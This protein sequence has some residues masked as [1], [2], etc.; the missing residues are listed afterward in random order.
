MSKRVELSS[1]DYKRT[2][3]VRREAQQMA[4]AAQGNDLK[5]AEQS[6][7]ILLAQVNT[8]M[9]STTFRKKDFAS[10]LQSKGIA[11]SPGSETLRKTSNR[12][13]A[14]SQTDVF[15]TSPTLIIIALLVKPTVLLFIF[16]S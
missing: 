7:Q 1:V 13:P 4:P 9:K 14:Y 3:R 10:R 11:W 6:G 5:V 8:L 12:P 15:L 2:M 16:V